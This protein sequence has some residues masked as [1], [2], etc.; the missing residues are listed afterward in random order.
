VARG[1]TSAPR[2]LAILRSVFD[3]QQA[4]ETS[5]GQIA[6]HVA[7]IRRLADLAAV[8]EQAVTALVIRIHM[9]ADA[10]QREALAH[11]RMSSAIARHPVVCVSLRHKEVSLGSTSD[12]S[13]HEQTGR[14]AKIAC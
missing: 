1:R 8:L 12:E 9:T 4:A 5:A 11:S 14:A 3:Y 2:G 6:Q 10:R 7:E 13:A